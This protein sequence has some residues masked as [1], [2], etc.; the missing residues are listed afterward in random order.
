MAGTHPDG[1]LLLYAIANTGDLE[2]RRQE[3]TARNN[4]WL[5]KWKSEVRLREVFSGTTSP[6]TRLSR[7]ALTSESTRGRPLLCSVARGTGIFS[8]QKTPLML[9]GHQ[10]DSD[11]MVAFAFLEKPPEEP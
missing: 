11:N 2:I 4:G 5:P 10:P 7:L 6:I 3:Q 8:G 1:R 9:V